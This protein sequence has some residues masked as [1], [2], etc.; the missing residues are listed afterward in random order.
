MKYEEFY[1]SLKG[2]ITIS[3]EEYQNFCDEFHKKRCVTMK[4]WLKEYNLADVT[5]FIEALEKTREHY[6]PD[7]IDLLKDAVSIPGISM[8]YV[9]NE[10][11][12]RK[13]YSE[14]DLYAP[15][16]PCK[17]ECSDDCEKASCKKC[18]EVRE[19]CKICT[20]NEAYEMLTTG[21]IGG[22]SI[23]FCRYAEAGVSQIRSHIYQHAK[24][25]RAVL[26]FDANSLYL[27]CSGQEMPCGK[28]KV[29][30]SNPEEKD[31]LIQN[32]LNDKLFGFFQVDIEVPEQLLDKFSEFS[33]LFILSEVPEDQIPQH[34]EDYKI[35][36]GRKKIK[37]NKKLLGV[38]KAEK[39]LL[40]SPLLKWYLNHG[41]QVTKIH[42]YIS[43]TSGRPFKWF[44]EEV[45]GARRA[46]DQDKNKRQLGDTAK[47]KGNSF[48][49]KMIEN[50]EKH[51]NTKFTTDE[52]LIDKIF[53][54]PCFDDLEEISEGT[55]EVRQ[56]KRQVTIT[57][58]YQCGIA[59]Y[60][61]AKLRMLEFYYD[62]VNKF[63]TRR[64]F[65]VIQMDTDSLYMAL[66]AEGFDEIIKPELKELY[67]D[68]K[69]KWLV[70]D[71][72][73]KRVPG[74][75]KPEF[76]GKRMIA[77]TSKCYFADNGDSEAG[78]SQEGMPKFSCKG[79]SRRQNKTSWERYKNALFGALDKV[80]NIGFRKKENHIVTY[81]QTKLG[82]SAYYDKRVVHEDGIHTS[83]L[84]A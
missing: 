9:L 49:G 63:C 73:S 16:E 53:R 70:T 2:G 8:M 32:V 69:P 30:S 47:L 67:K 13:K 72:Y 50:L 33:P 1:S 4:D 56:R 28:E 22:P 19:N 12:K 44:P 34:M 18:K 48:Y 31:K 10:A 83:C 17:C 82:L 6:Y 68:E 54:S 75:F 29:F 76:K 46:A 43:Y 51:M 60:Q 64:D 74:L 26:G 20:K 42:N 25:C 77:L 3:K 55:F 62:F 57:R 35:N 78:A 7:E 80:T 59:V 21:M 41:L 14:P 39:I 5:P 79:V 52:N 38:M 81:E 71:E 37:N 27:F 24:T 40:Y 23:V 15:G 65:E 11:S 58:P 66:T 84:R 45:S 61:L 36:T